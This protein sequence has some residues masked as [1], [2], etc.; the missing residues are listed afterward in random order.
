ME[1]FL[2]YEQFGAIG[3]GVADDMPAIV[4]TH[5][6][7]NRLGLPVRAAAY[8]VYRIGSRAAT[9]E[10]A[11]DTDWGSASLVIDD[12]ELDRIDTPVFCVRSR[13]Q[14]EVPFTIDRLTHGQT[15]IDNPTGKELFV[16]VWNAEHIDYIRY[17]GNQDDGTARYDCFNIAPDGTLSSPV[18]FDFEK[19]T[20]V[21]A[22]IVDADTLTISGGHFTTIANRRE[23]FYDYHNRG[24][25]VHRSRVRIHGLTHSVTEELEH[26]A[27][28]NGFVQIG[29][30]AHITVENCVF[31]AH[32]TYYTTG[33]AGVTVPMGTYDIA[34]GS[35]IDVT[36][37]G[38]RQTTDL[39]DRAYW[40]LIGSN[41][42][43]EI[44]IENCSFSRFDA[45]MGVTNCTIR[46]ST[47]GWMG[48]TAIGFGTFAMENVTSYGNWFVDLREDF[49]SSW[50]G[51]FVVKN[52]TWH[53]SGKLH[54]AFHATNPGIHN[55]GY[56]C[57]LPNVELDGFT[58]ICDDASDEKTLYIF[59]DPNRGVEPGTY[60]VELPAYVTISGGV[61]GAEKVALC[62]KDMQSV[63]FTVL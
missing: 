46:N 16:Q 58:V 55:F 32:R 29:G 53:C 10:I 13:N 61:N 6:E 9:A 63:R 3:D 14:T 22:D 25:T 38:C 59:T 8:A 11:T 47:L 56:T 5:A 4:R 19:V 57:V 27:P 31:C 12:R 30:C 28:Y 49:G 20:L 23:S 37:R 17:G 18:S 42:C 60:P 44:T 43:R 62:A 34:M 7:A 40:G 52:C 15:H 24:I 2:T 39:T 45:H 1:E 51:K 54:P 33:S 41:N 35:A 21:R 48:I 50:R 26:G 36:F